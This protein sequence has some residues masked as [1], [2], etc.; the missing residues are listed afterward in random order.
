[1]IVRRTAEMPDLFA[2][3][4]ERLAEGAMILR[5][6]AIDDAARLMAAIQAIQK[7]APFRHMVTP[8]GGRMSAAMTNCGS[9]GWVT[10]RKGYRYTAEDPETGKPWPALPPLFLDLARRAAE[11]ADFPGFVPDG[12]LI[13]RYEPGA[14]MGLHQDKD[15]QDRT[16]PIVSVSLGLPVVFLWGGLARRDRPVKIA[17]ASGDVAVW[18][19]PSRFVYHGVAPLED[20]E[21]PVTGRYRYNLT[22]RKA[23]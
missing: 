19:G 10:D 2:E 11:A 9:R 23:V 13:N 22:L 20:G 6:F 8:G 18:G 12:C 21:H 15:E 16:A 14:R 3:P 17:L 7:A 1:M 4:I 5:G